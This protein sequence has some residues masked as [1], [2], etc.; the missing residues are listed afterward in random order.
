[1]TRILRSRRLWTFAIF[2]ALVFFLVIAWFAYPYFS[3]HEMVR[4]S[5][6]ALDA[7]AA[8]VS[9]EGPAALATPPTKLG[10]FNVGKIEPLPHGFLFESDYGNPFDWN[11]LAYS[12]E[13]LP[14]TEYD[15]AGN[16]RQSFQS[17]GGN[18]YTVIRWRP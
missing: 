17:L 9:A 18:W 14:G 10:Y 13:P 3:F 15:T 11:G 6:P 1:M 16:E 4:R 2:T 8:R 7:Y 12:T 5:I